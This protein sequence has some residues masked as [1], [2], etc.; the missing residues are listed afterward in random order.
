VNISEFLGT[1]SFADVLIVLGLFGFGVLGYAQGAIRRLVGIATMT[2][3]FFLAAQLSVPVGSFLA[4]HWV[5]FPAQYAYM[6]GFLILFIAGFVAFALVVQGTYSKV[7]LF[8]KHPIVDEALG[9]ILGVI[10]GLLLL[11]YLTIILDHFFLSPSF[12]P[13]ADEVPLLANL[14]TAID[15]SRIG[16]TL[17]ETAIPNFLSLVRFLVPSGILATYGIG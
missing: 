4:Q 2:F 3:S 7:E 14:W 5:Q 12:A 10:Q 13:D 17:H 9:G 1:L 11:M 8:A 16:Q 15:G 6:L